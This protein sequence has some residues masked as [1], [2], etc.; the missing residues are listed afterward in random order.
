MDEKYYLM[1]QQGSSFSYSR[2]LL[3][4]S[5]SHLRHIDHKVKLEILRILAREEM[6]PSSIA[7]KLKINE[8]NVYYH[9]NHL[10]DAG[11]VKVVEEKKIRGTVARKYALVSSNF[12]V[13]LGG[14][15]KAIRNLTS[16]SD[17]MDDFLSPFLQGGVFDGK[18]I[19]G[20]PDPHGPHK[21]RA[22]DGH[23]AVDLAL[24]LG[25]R[26]TVPEDF[27]VGLDV[28]HSLGNGNL[29]VVGGPVTNSIMS[30]VNEHL[31]VRFSDSKPWGLISKYDTYTDDTIGIVARLPNPF[32]KEKWI[33]A[34]AGIRFIGT[35]A[36]I[37]AF[38]RHTDKLLENFNNQKKFVKVVQGFDMDGDGKIDTCEILE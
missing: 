7:N 6:Y 8:Q 31:P 25:S 20:N 32:N 33:I 29:I 14:E 38:T 16:K 22:R 3:L 13:S 1:K 19:V 34:I 11:V 18:I 24:F 23:Y 28:D 30:E 4:K 37:M 5:P 10:K 12:A 17:K 15:W 21:A 36:A 2:A 27:S 26:V 35:K 9:L